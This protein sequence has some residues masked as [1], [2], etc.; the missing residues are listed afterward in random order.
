MLSAALG[1]S[2]SIQRSACAAL[3]DKKSQ[4]RVLPSLRQDG[5]M[6]FG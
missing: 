5:A 4:G 3:V 2:A 1:C 6:E